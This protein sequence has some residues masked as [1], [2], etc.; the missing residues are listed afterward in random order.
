MLQSELNNFQDN[1]EK[2]W[3]ILLIKSTTDSYLSYFYKLKKQF[4]KILRYFSKI[5]KKYP[6][7]KNIWIKKTWI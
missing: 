3:S 4:D 6:R 2:I 1:L 7:L 5:R